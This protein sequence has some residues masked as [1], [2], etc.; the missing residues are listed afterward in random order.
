MPN[1]SGLMCSYS[2]LSMRTHLGA[3]NSVSGTGAYK[4]V[5]YSDGGGIKIDQN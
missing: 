2:G 3:Y 5:A 4:I 1:C